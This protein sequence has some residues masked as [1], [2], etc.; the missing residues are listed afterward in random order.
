M[1]VVFCECVLASSGG[2]RENKINALRC[3]SA[4]KAELLELSRAR[5]RGGLTQTNSNRSNMV[6]F[7][8]DEQLIERERMREN[9]RGFASAFS[10]RIVFNGFGRAQ[11]ARS[12]R[13]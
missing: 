6:L 1:A 10:E 3:G 8:A 13:A 7:S 4:V 5:V 2:R 11:C 12:A 9:A